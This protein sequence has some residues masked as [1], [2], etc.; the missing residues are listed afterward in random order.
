[1]FNA[2]IQCLDQWEYYLLCNSIINTDVFHLSETIQNNPQIIAASD[3]SVSSSVRSYGW[4]CSLPHDQQLA[5]N[6]G[7]VFNS[8]PSSF[9]AEA[10]G[11]LSYLKFLYRISQFTHSPLPKETILYTD[12]ASLIAK[13]S[14]IKKWLYFFPNATMDPDWDI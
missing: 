3:R 7:P 14:E 2:Y 5:T 10:Y 11:L 8:L 13:I 1:M 9:C 6:H 12:S 4:I